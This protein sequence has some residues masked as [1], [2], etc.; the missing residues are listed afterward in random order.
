MRLH[1]R[2][3]TNPMIETELFK[4]PIH[5]FRHFACL[6]YLKVLF[7][8]FFLRYWPK[9]IV[10]HRFDKRSQMFTI[11]WFPVRASNAMW[12]WLWSTLEKHQRD[13]GDGVFSCV[14]GFSFCLFC[15]VLFIYLSF[16]ACVIGKNP[17]GSW[18]TTPLLRT[19]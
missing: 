4:F 11:P 3:N 15:F 8:C 18:S 9:V 5:Y 2:R 10:S 14:C 17:Q 19:V 13:R 12:M 16:F 7:V 6:S 1:H